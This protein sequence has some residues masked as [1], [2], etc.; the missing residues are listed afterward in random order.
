MIFLLFYIVNTLF[1]QSFKK[2]ATIAKLSLPL[3]FSCYNKTKTKRKGRQLP[4][5]SA[6][7]K[8]PEKKAT[9]TKLSSP[10]SSSCCNKTK[11]KEGDSNKPPLLQCKK[12]KKR[13][14]QAT[15]KQKK[16][17]D[18]GKSSPSLRHYIKK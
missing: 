11:Q 14:R 2:K 6:F 13:R 7:Q 9:A 15:I 4:S 17:R 3:F 12:K 18:G 5:P 8:K 1:T 16:E 10:F